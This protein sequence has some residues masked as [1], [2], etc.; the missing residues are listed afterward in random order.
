LIHSH[1]GSFVCFPAIKSENLV[2]LKKLREALIVARALANLGSS[3]E[4]WEHTIVF[5]ISLKFSLETQCEWNKTLRKSREY[6]SYEQMHDFLTVYTRRLTY[7][8]SIGRI[9]IIKSC[10]SVNSVSVL[11]CVNC[12]GSHNLATYEDFLS[13]LIPQR[14]TFVRKKRV[15]FN[16]LRPNHFTPKFPSRSRCMHCRRTYYSLLHLAAV[17]VKAPVDRALELDD[18]RTVPNASSV[19]VANVQN[20][21]AEV[22]SVKIL[23]TTAWL[24]LYTPECVPVF[25]GPSLTGSEI[26]GQLYFGVSLPNSANE[27]AARRAPNT[28]F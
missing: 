26:D 20:V 25:Q 22:A 21:Q 18:S 5:I 23:L 8:E 4:H 28:L 7:Y 3:V 2:E 14:S 1:L 27:T 11:T 24:D 19:L 12:A 10:T 6:A 13:K 9:S 15:C 16:C 17:T